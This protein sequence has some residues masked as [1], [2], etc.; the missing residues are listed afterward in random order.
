MTLEYPYL[1]RVLTPLYTHLSKDLYMQTNKNIMHKA[2]D[3]TFAIVE[4]VYNDGN[5]KKFNNT[6][7]QMLQHHR[8]QEL[9]REYAPYSINYSSINRL[10]GDSRILDR[11]TRIGKTITKSINNI[12]DE[13]A[14][15]I[16]K[17]I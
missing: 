15:L 2:S 7:S 12:D 17:N 3:K 8:Q 11:N 4:N 14:L 1:M 6:S 9:K 10:V 5:W 13:Q 16:S